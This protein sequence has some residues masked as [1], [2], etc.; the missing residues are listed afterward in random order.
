M[1]IFNLGAW[2]GKKVVD[3][4]AKLIKTRRDKKDGTC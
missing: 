1:L 3:F 4:I 2:F